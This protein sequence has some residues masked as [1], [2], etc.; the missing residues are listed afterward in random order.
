MSDKTSLLSR[1]PDEL[2]AS[3]HTISL[4]KQRLDAY[5]RSI[6]AN[7]SLNPDNGKVCW[8]T[9]KKDIKAKGAYAHEIRKLPN[10][11]GL[12]NLLG[13][14]IYYEEVAYYLETHHWP[15]SPN[16]IQE[17]DEAKRQELL[18]LLR[19]QED[20]L[21]GRLVERRDPQRQV[22]TEAHCII[23]QPPKRLSRFGGY[24]G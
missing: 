10:T 13:E 4:F 15:S 20:L 5:G 1:A 9:P 22:L 16:A 11:E 3:P 24:N 21:S 19:Y 14:Y 23:R 2:T 12:C 6:D 18:D 17:L 7:V 8:L